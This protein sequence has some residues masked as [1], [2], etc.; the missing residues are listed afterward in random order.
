MDPKGV[1]IVDQDGNLLTQPEEQ[2]GGIDKIT[3]AQREYQ[4]KVERELEQKIR[5]ILARAVG[6]DKV[7]SK[8]DASIE[9]KK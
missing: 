6:H 7:V 8:V 4:R 3:S 5:E 9:Y 1:T 2:D